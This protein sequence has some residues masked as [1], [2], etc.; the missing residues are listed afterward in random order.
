MI[1]CTSKSDFC[2]DSS[3]GSMFLNMKLYKKINT[4]DTIALDGGYTL[5]IK[6]VV[7]LL[8]SKG[9]KF[10]DDNF[11]YPIRKN[12][13]ESLTITEDHFN[14]TFG[15]FRSKV[16]NQFSGLGN[17][18]Y[19]FNNNKSV[20]KM[21]NIKFYNLQFRVAC[22]LK[23]ILMFCKLFNVPTLPHYKFWRTE[24]FE[25]PI[26]R[27]LFDIVVSNEKQN[28]NKLNKMLELQSSFLNIDI[29]DTPMVDNEYSDDETSNNLSDSRDDYKKSKELS[30]KR[31]LKGKGKERAYK[32]Y[33][34]EAIVSHKIENNIYYFLVKWKD[35]SES[36]NTWL[37]IN[38]FNEKVMLKTYI[39]TNNLG[40][41]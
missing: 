34:I 16:E 21:D 40:I 5:F 20:V 39:E 26:E 12:P 24:N 33:E 27:K 29:A 17:K 18:F 28:K 14:K 10:I 9:Y 41:L 36:D 8:V 25:F 31:K 30:K 7:D 32:S 13:G 23:N 22:L 1:I 15:S 4:K 35:Y 3:N 6:Q 19:R 38:N 37:T 11:V 2:S